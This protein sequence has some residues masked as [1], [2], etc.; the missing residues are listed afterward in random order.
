MVLFW[1]SDT[2]NDPKR[3]FINSS[4]NED[5]RKAPKRRLAERRKICEENKSP[6][7]LSENY[8]QL[9][10]FHATETQN[11][12]NTPLTLASEISLK[13]RSSSFKWK[14]AA[15]SVIRTRRLYEKSNE[16]D[17]NVITTALDNIGISA[18]APKIP[19]SS[20]K[21]VYSFHRDSQHMNPIDD[22]T[23]ENN[24]N[25]ILRM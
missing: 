9:N 18:T 10:E 17:L 19:L 6:D 16:L 23:G 14:L 2:V 7:P 21:P 12:S 24:A 4:F 25:L 15:K 8:E 3:I 13:R 11:N 1:F 22:C 20:C 5:T